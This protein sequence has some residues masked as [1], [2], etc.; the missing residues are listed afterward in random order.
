MVLARAP[1]VIIEL[2]YGEAW[3]PAQDRIGTARVVGAAIRA[4]GAK[5]PRHVAD[6][7]TSSSCLDR[8]CR[9]RPN[10]SLRS[11]IPE[12]QPMKTLVSLSSGK[13]SAWM[14]HVL[15]QTPRRRARRPA[16]DGQRI[17]RAR[18][19]ARR[20]RRRCSHAQADALGLPLRMLPIP[21]PAPTRC[22][23]GDDG[24]RQRRGRRRLHAHGVRRSVPRGHPR[25]TASGSSPAPDSTPLFPLFG[26]DTAALAREMIAAGLK[27]R[28]TCVDPRVLD[29]RF[30]GARVRHGAARRTAARSRPVR[31]ARRVPLVCLRRPDVQ[32]GR[33]CRRRRGGRA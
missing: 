21:S 33:S 17:G 7:A 10:A 9:S 32:R 1:E 19:D 3:P 4:G 24:R 18:R 25:A 29:R 16:H 8:A 22:T 31:R 23:S 26:A 14:I 12:S 20:A 30:V 2:H 28:L 13:D 15:R 11:S 6:A 27:A 5:R